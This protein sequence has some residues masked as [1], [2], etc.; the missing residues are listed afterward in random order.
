MPPSA[1]MTLI[2]WC[3]APICSPCEYMAVLN[4]SKRKFALSPAAPGTRSEW[5][6]CKPPGARVLD[7]PFF[8]TRARARGDSPQFILAQQYSVCLASGFWVWGR[9]SGELAPFPKWGRPEGKNWFIP[10]MARF[11]IILIMSV[12][13]HKILCA[14]VYA[15]Q[16]APEKNTESEFDAVRGEKKSPHGECV[17]YKSSARRAWNIRPSCIRIW[18]F[19][20][21]LWIAFH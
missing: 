5:L 12:W 13:I 20:V 16:A 19:L 15:L 4:Q 11:Q 10:E 14:Y 2:R 18:R 21:N 7:S 6:F 8:W 3:S 1:V 9:A 17:R